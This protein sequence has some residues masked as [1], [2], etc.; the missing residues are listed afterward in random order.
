MMTNFCQALDSGVSTIINFKK[1]IIFLSLCLLSCNVG[2]QLN[3]LVSLG[4][5][6]YKDTCKSKNTPWNKCHMQILKQPCQEMKKKRG[7][8]YSI[9]IYAEYLLFV[10]SALQLETASVFDIINGL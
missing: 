3:P 10:I 6:I 4:T 5:T 1:H 8:N 2:V 9:R 7:K